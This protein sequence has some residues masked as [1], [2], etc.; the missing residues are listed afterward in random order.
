MKKM[1]YVNFIK[2]FEKRFNNSG[3]KI[4]KKLIKLSAL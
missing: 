1:K 4:Y 2:R 3:Y